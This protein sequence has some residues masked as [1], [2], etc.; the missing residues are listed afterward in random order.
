[1]PALLARIA[2]LARAR[3][4]K[5]IGLVA[6]GG[7]ERLWSR[8]GFAAEGEAAGGPAGGAALASYGPGALAMRGDA[9]RFDYIN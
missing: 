8:L 6:V 1:V 4:L 9:S 3:G 2:A 7:T 5:A